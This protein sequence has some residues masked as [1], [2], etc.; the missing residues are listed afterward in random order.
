M[1]NKFLNILIIF[2]TFTIIMQITAVVSA[3][4]LSATEKKNIEDFLKKEENLMFSST[5]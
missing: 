1:K 5:Y 4:D 2:I 3:T